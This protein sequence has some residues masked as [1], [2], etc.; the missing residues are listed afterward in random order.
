MISDVSKIFTPNDKIIFTLEDYS[1]SY[2]TKFFK[3][4][5]LCITF[6]DE[7]HAQPGFF[8][9]KRLPNKCKGK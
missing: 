1:C 6:T 8:H 7:N 3:L 9:E 5:V 2:G 4:K